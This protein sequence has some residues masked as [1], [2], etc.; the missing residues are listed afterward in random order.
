M[1]WLMKKFPPKMLCLWTPTIVRET[2]AAAAAAPV[3]VGV[4]LGEEALPT[5]PGHHE[6]TVGVLLFNTAAA[7]LKY[8]FLGEGAL[9][10]LG[11]VLPVLPTD[12]GQQDA[13]GDEEMTQS[14]AEKNLLMRSL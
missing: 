11:G 10:G 14:A 9:V 8:P 4:P 7:K 5:D 13:M 2:T 3:T 6:D 1:W 12:P